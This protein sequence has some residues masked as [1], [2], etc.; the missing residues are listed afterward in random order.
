MTTTAAAAATATAAAS[1]GL[2]LKVADVKFVAQR[3]Y[4][5]AILANFQRNATMRRSLCS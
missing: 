4:W 1:G 2:G 5:T 3:D